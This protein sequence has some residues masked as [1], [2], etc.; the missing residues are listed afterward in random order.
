MDYFKLNLVIVGLF[1][2]ISLI[3]GFLAGRKVTTIRDYALANKSYGTGPLV[4]TYLAT[5]IGGYWVFGRPKEIAE[6]GIGVVILIFGWAIGMFMRAKYIAPR[7]FPFRNC[8][9]LGDMVGELY[10]SKPKVLVGILSVVFSSIIVGLN[11]SCM[12][13]VFEKFLGLNGTL[14]IVVSTMVVALYSVRGGIRAVT[15]TDMIQF[16]VL[17]GTL[18][19]LAI[20]AVN[21]IGGAE[22][23]LSQIPAEK[24]NFWDTKKT[25]CYISL[26]S[27][28]IFFSAMMF[29]PAQFD[30]MLMAKSPYHMSKMLYISGIGA[31]LIITIIA[32]ITFSALLLYPDIDT[33]N[34]M[35]YMINELIP[36]WAQGFAMAGIIAILFSTADSYMH[37]AGV[38]FTHDIAKPIRDIYQLKTN[39]LT[40]A[41][42]STV[43]VSILSIIFA[44]WGK[45]M[46]RPDYF[47]SIIPPILAAPVLFSIFGIKPEE[48]AFWISGIAAS[49]SLIICMGA[50]STYYPVIS[51]FAILISTCVSAITYIAIHIDIN[52]GIFLIKTHGYN[53][54]EAKV[55]KPNMEKF[56][57]RIT[58]FI[59]FP[60]H[61]ASRCRRKTAIY[62]TPPYVLFGIFYLAVLVMP[63]FMSEQI[64]S[65][66]DDLM[67]GLRFIGILL[68][69]LLI[70]ES[71]WPTIFL[72]YL[73]AFWYIT[74]A[75]C[76]PFLSTML[77]CLTNGATEYL[78][79]IAVTIMF[80]M[81]LVDWVSATSIGII[82]AG[83]AALLY[84]YG[85]NA[86][87]CLQESHFSFHTMYLLGYQLIFGAAIGLIFSRRKQSMLETNKK[88]NIMIQAT[89]D[90]REKQL[91]DSLSVEDNISKGLGMREINMIERIANLRGL[92]EKLMKL[93]PQ[94]KDLME[95]Y[96]EASKTLEYLENL[97][98]RAKDYLK[99]NVKTVSMDLF[100]SSINEM[101]NV[102]SKDYSI[103]IR[104][105]IT[106]FECDAVELSHVFA[107][108][109]HNI[110]VLN[111]EDDHITIDIANTEVSYTLT[112]LPNYEKKLKALQF[113]IST[114]QSLNEKLFPNLYKEELK[115]PKD[116]LP[117]KDNTTDSVISQRVM[118]AHFGISKTIKNETGYT[119]ILVVPIHLR[120]IRPLTLDLEIPE[121]VIITWPGALEL[122]KK[123]KE[124]IKIKAP[125]INLKKI[126]TAIELIKKYHYHQN[127]HSGEPYY[128]HPVAVAMI[129]LESSQEEDA[130]LGALLHDTLEDTALNPMD[131]KTM[132]GER[133]TEIVLGASKIDLERIPKFQ[134]NEEHLK[135]LDKKD[136]IVLSIKIS[137]R[138]HNMRT[139]NGHKS[140][141]KRRAIAQETL[142]FFVPL[143][144]ELGMIKAYEEL[145]NLAEKELTLP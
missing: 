4:M 59:L 81:L 144:K 13:F 29:D 75:Y 126:D 136:L 87:L 65:E 68:C 25:Y 48:K 85:V 60:F 32:T 94:A 84:K 137:D 108:A 139:L 42:A 127:R 82:S 7:M 114:A 145:K 131:L 121:E 57:C 39:E 112:S 83:A 63:Y 113:T 62:G 110:H 119:V 106:E 111:V 1:L 95:E 43:V 27:V 20:L 10:G 92:C 23:L 120:E 30:R 116:I 31:M 130:I 15:A 12:G 96:S 44:I 40:W 41:R 37:S 18:A 55:W 74:L 135:S 34:I 77:L 58:N 76:L 61:F 47:L 21:K 49:I 38:A 125:S 128:L 133:V 117:E 140:I 33:S 52:K 88:I 91:R 89:S 102:Y 73:P 35:L 79:N 70:T 45:H 66:Y 51:G 46:F 78:I 93:A 17:L 67:L 24:F 104:T 99:L 103:V 90:M 97:S 138:L 124:E 6:Y 50:N 11:I 56:I 109:L 54:P 142:N 105:E 53:D 107:D 100:L 28:G 134:S 36:K 22:M 8:L 64:H 9:T 141:E 14:G 123:F 71:I 26:I 129:E 19:V 5:F 132:F 118:A 69:S 101:A 86:A 80:L 72:P 2:L 122:E 115:N 3:V 98:E 16:V 143:A